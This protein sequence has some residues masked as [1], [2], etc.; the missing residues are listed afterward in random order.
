MRQLVL[1]D[2]NVYSSSL[3]I[4]LAVGASLFRQG[5]IQ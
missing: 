1:D 2:R 4:D 3:V 5:I